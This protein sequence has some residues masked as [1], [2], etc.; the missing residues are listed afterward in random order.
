VPSGHAIFLF[1]P[2]AEKLRLCSRIADLLHLPMIAQK[3]GFSGHI[4]EK[5]QRKVDRLEKA[6]KELADFR[7]QAKRVTQRGHLKRTK[8]TSSSDGVS[9][10]TAKVRPPYKK[11]LSRRQLDFDQSNY[12]LTED[13]YC[14]IKCTMY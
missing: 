3:D 7:C 8:E 5:C 9:P 6:M 11:H 14:E 10:D 13:S 2:K 12:P 1:S 4:C